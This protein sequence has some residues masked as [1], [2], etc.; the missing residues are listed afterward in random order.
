M[1]RPRQR[2][3]PINIRMSDELYEATVQAARDQHR[4]PRQLM[5][6]ILRSAMAERG[7]LDY[8]DV[9]PPLVTSGDRIPDG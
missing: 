5:R 2:M 8:S 6:F 4:T 3:A 1:S 7:L 9:A